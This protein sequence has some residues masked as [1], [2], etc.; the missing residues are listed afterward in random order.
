MHFHR[1]LRNTRVFLQLNLCLNKTK[2]ILFILVWIALT[3]GKYSLCSLVSSLAFLAIFFPTN[4]ITHPL[5]LTPGLKSDRRKLS[6][7]LHHI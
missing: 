7:K 6:E 1:W 2:F 5:H 3:S 4:L